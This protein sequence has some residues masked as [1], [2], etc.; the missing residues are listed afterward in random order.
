MDKQIQEIN[1]G[2]YKEVPRVQ[3]LFDCEKR[4]LDTIIELGLGELVLC[5][6]DANQ[7]NI[8]WNAQTRT[9]GFIDF[10]MTLKNYPALEL[11]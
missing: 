5:H 10:E 9:L 11:G 8:I 1:E 3:V 7:K 6:N 4:L 2:P